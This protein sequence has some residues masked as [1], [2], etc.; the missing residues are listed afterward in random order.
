MRLRQRVASGGSCQANIRVVDLA[1]ARHVVAEVSVRDQTGPEF[2]LTDWRSVPSTLPSPLTSPANCPKVTAAEAS[3]PES[4]FTPV[5]V[6]VTSEPSQ[7][8]WMLLSNTVTVEPLIVVLLT[9]PQLVVVVPENC[10]RLREGKHDLGRSATAPYRHS[11]PGVPVSGKSI[12]NVPALPCFL[13]EAA[14]TSVSPPLRR[15]CRVPR[16]R[17]RRWCQHPP[18]T[19]TLPLGSNVAV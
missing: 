11:T 8:V 9:L 16:S 1:V 19:S 10:N 14:L 18:A 4:P 7:V 15:L 13:R 12:S 2:A 17:E 3:V 6:T 5:K